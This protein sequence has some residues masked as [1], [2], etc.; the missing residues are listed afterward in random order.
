MMLELGDRPLLH[1]DNL[2]SI[3]NEVHIC[4]GDQDDMADKIFSEQVSR[5]LPAGTFHELNE[6]PHPIEKVDLEKL[7][8]ITTLQ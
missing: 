2:K 4:L 6:T 7:I 5:W 1:E 8:R 3:S